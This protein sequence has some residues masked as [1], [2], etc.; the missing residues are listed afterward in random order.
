MTNTTK[1]PETKPN[2]GT[3][4]SLG[5]SPKI[6]QVLEQLKFTSPTPIQ[7]QSIPAALE[8]KDVIG[9]AQTGTGKTLA[10]GIPMVQRLSNGTGQGLVLLPT[11]E[12]A[13]QVA[14]TLQKISRNNGLKTAVLIGGAS[15][16]MQ[17]TALRRNPN[18]IVATPG[19]LVDHLK[20]G[21]LKLNNVK[22]CVLD[23]ADRMFDIGF[24]TQIKQVLG[25]ISK[26][27]Q[28]MLFSATMPPAIAQLASAHLSMP[29]RIEVAP[30]GSAAS[31]VEQ[32]FYMVNRDVKLQL[33]E[34]MLADH[35]GS[36]LVFCRTKH[37]AKKIAIVIR[38]MGHTSAEIHSNRSLAQRKEALEGFKTGKFRILVA[39]DIAARGIDVVGIEVVI[40]YDLPENSEDYVHRIGRT[41]RAGYFGKAISFATPDQRHDIRKIE[42][43]IRKTIRISTVLPQLPPRRTMPYVDDSSER[44]FG[45]GGG[46]GFGGRRPS[47]GGF[48]GGRSSDGSSR[49]SFGGSRPASSSTS[50][51]RPAFGGASSAPRSQFRGHSGNGTGAGKAKPGFRRSR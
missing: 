25:L 13:L 3:F 18:I 48:G 21:N 22:V 23:E 9:I 34:K 1:Q 42:S 6:L 30:A 24:A 19:R 4:Q 8:G 33:L 12:L 16:Y 10:F 20:Q 40:N 11:R 45:G 41:G 51:S 43:L 7:H 32:E 26:E 28:I 49:P 27:R 35:K 15:M 50:A 31:Q 2:T 36:I 44:R 37:S 17:V 29:L 14:E 5:I 39:T 47:G 46:S 38:Q